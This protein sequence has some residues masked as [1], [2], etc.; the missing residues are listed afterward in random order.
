MLVIL[1]TTLLASLYL[2]QEVSTDEV[3]DRQ[4]AA[5][6][7]VVAPSEFVARAGDRHS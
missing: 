6:T 1:G 5:G 2:E 7:G 3:E 4:L